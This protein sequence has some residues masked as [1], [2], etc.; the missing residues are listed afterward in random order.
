MPS[1]ARDVVTASTP[2]APLLQVE[3]LSVEYPVRS[4]FLSREKRVVHAVDGVS[5]EL[6]PGETLGLV[7]ESG[8]GKSTT[9]LAVLRRVPMSGGTVRFD[10]EDIGGLQGERLRR[11]RSNAQMVFQDPY[12]SLNPRMKIG[13]IV[14]EPIVVHERGR[15]MKDADVRERVADLLGLC[16]LPPDAA[17]R[18]PHAFSG[19]QRQRV[20]IARALAVQPRLIVADEP[21]SALD[22][23]IQAQVVNLMTDLQRKL[24]I[25]YLFISHNLAVVQAIAD[26]IAIMYAGQIVEAAPVEDIYERAR[27]PYTQALLSAVPIP[28]PEIQRT[29]QRIVL[30][31]DVPNPMSPPSG[32]RFHGRC[33]Y[34]QPKCAVEPPPLRPV[35]EGHLAACHFAEEIAAQAIVPNERLADIRGS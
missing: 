14:G 19:G 34:A 28:D 17:Q 9:G 32:C 13:D 24:G 18:Y 20:A 21:V 16:G 33:K 11:W 1:E 26:R 6:A 35:G 3:Q 30:R 2:D 4:G 5:F 23:S 31:G 22:V 27:H 12:A 29:R 15:R 25:S 7:G 10:G 8:S